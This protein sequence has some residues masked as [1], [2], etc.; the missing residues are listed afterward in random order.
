MDI[1]YRLRSLRE[2]KHLSQGDIEQHTGLLRYYISH[3]ENGHTIPGVETLTKMARAL[4]IPLYQ[5]LYDED[6]PPSTS[7]GKNL[8]GETGKDARFLNKLR[9]SL[10]HMKDRDRKLLLR[11]AEQIPK[12]RG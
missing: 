12:R 11:L 10:A 1:G 8:W 6:T 9:H 2:E 7:N 3:V 5:V 4:E